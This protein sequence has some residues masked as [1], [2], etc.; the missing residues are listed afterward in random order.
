MKILRLVHG[1][2]ARAA[3]SRRS[4][5]TRSWGTPAP[6]PVDAYDAV[7]VC[8]GAVIG[9]CLGAQLLADALP[10]AAAGVAGVAANAAA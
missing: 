8:G 4:A 9:I 6:V 5:A 3:T 7:M 10:D 2:G 1:E